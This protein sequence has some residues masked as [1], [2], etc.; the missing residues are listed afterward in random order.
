MQHKKGSETLV[1]DESTDPKES[2]CDRCNHGMLCDFLVGLLR[3]LSHFKVLRGEMYQGT[4]HT[5]LG[6]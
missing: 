4:C 5:V 6:R 1:G 3:F 2:L